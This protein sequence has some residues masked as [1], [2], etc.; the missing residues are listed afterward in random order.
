MQE[1]QIDLKLHHY[2]KENDNRATVIYYLK[3]CFRFN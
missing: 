1:Q 2:L 3:D